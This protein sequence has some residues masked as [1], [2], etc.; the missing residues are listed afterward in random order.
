M[1]LD[2]HSVYLNYTIICSKQKCKVHKQIN[3]SSKYKILSSLKDRK[4]RLE[5][6]IPNKY[7]GMEENSIRSNSKTCQ[8]KQAVLDH[9]I[10]CLSYS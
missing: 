5:Q 4:H 8:S 6:N 7:E 2:N 1:L 10:I 9:K 3:I